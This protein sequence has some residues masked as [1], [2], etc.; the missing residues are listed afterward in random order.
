MEPLQIFGLSVIIGVIV[1]FLW[2]RSDREEP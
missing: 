1:I 2:S